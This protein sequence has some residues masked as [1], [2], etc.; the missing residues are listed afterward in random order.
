MKSKFLILTINIGSTSTKLGLFADEMPLFKETVNHKKQELS[1]LRNMTERQSFRRQVI[2]RILA[3]HPENGKTIDLI[4]SRGGL[5]HPLN[6]GPYLIND[7]M[8]QDLSEANYGWHPSNLGPLIAHQMGEEM[9]VPA[10]IFDSPVTDEMEQIARISGLK[11]F[12]RKAAFHVLNQK[13][14]A[15]KAARKFGKSYENM[16]FIVCHLG[17]GI[18]I[19]AHRKGRI[20]DGGHG[21]N[22]GPFTPQ[23][24]GS[25]P[26]KDVIELCFSGRFT[27]DELEEHLMS[28]GGIVSYL[29][30]HDM[31]QIEENIKD[32][33]KEAH[34]I[35]R[36]MCYQISKDIG[37]MASVLRGKIDAIVLTGNLCYSTLIV[38]EIKSNIDF[39]AGLLISWLQFLN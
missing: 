35:I 33:D 4:V 26:L 28:H 13:S 36:A 24:T 12:E 31:K 7:A 19:C 34:L 2:D 8:C 25:L 39:L 15:K 30:T 20:I 6:S 3:K 22:E 11:E 5:T 14:A 32:G 21:L 29:E 16:A 1:Q 17:G 18:T 38:D 27:K 9:E 37:A 10:I 23:R